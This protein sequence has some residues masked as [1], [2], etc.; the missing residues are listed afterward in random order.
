MLELPPPSH[1]PCDRCGASVA[2]DI[3]AGHVCNE[4]RRLDYLLFQA[5]GEIEGFADEFGRWLDSPRGRFEQRDAE[6]RRRS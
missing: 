1:M 3:P 4:E 6:R 2:R 5:R